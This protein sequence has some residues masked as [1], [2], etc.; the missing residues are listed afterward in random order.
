MARTH[1]E[2][3]LREPANRASKVRAVDGKHLELLIINIPHP[4]CDVSGFAI[5]S[6]DDGILVCGEPS[7]ASGKLLQSAERE[8]GLVSKLLFA[9][10]GRKEVAHDRH[11]Q[12]NPNDTVK[13][14]SQFHK[15][16]SSGYSVF[17]AHR[18]PPWAEFI[19]EILYGWP[20]NFGR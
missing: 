12:K 16:C 15:S 14:H 7:L 18:G 2:V 3:R 9:T 1:E 8:P 20:G 6:I 19:E 11:G 5:P 17:C 4:A 13:K 10:H